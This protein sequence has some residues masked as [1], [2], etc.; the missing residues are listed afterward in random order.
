LG[1]NDDDDDDDDDGGDGD[2]GGGSGDDADNDMTTMSMMM[3]MMMMVVMVMM[4]ITEDDDDDTDD[5]DMTL[6]PLIMLMMMMMDDNDA[7]LKCMLVLPVC[8]QVHQLSMCSSYNQISPWIS[9]LLNP[10]LSLRDMCRITIR[11]ALPISIDSHV[12]LLPLPR[13]LKDFC[14]FREFVLDH[15]DCKETVERDRSLEEK[16]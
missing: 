14:M 8:T 4:I 16:C 13:A 7:M 10:L 12:E 11:N 3:M 6:T 1:A 15:K 5:D 9:S 2:D